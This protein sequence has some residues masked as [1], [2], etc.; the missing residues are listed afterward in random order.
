L[1]S[2]AS[3]ENA[4]AAMG[5]PRTIWFRGHTATH[6]LLPSLFRFSEGVANERRI[7]EAFRRN[8]TAAEFSGHVLDTLVALHH[9]YAPTRLLAWTDRLEV[10]L[11]CALVRESDE[12]AL[13]LLDPIALNSNS[14]IAELVTMDSHDRS[15]REFLDGV[16][17]FSWGQRPVALTAR[18][19]C[20]PNL[21]ADSSF[22][23]HGTDSRSLDAQFPGCVRKV[24]LTASDKALAAER[25]LARATG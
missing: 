18:A 9:S 4:L 17:K 5:N 11:F 3:I 1:P 24:V 23:L 13:F 20:S 14:Q 21:I 2:I 22:T 6:R 19:S 8:F 15:A 10:A 25:V 16:V 12:A 7:I